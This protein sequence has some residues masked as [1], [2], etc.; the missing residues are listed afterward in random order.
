MAAALARFDE[1]S[2][3]LIAARALQRRIDRKYLLSQR[4]LEPVLAGLVADYRVARAGDV[5]TARYETVY[6]DTVHR[7]L[8]DDHRRGR[9]PRYKVRLRHHCDRR[10]TFLEVKRRGGCTTKMR[11]EL[12]FTGGRPDLQLSASELN[13]AAR[14]FVDAHCPIG[15]DRL[16]PCVWVTFTRLTLVGKT[17][18]ERATFDWNIA[19]GDQSRSEQLPALVVAEVKQARF[20]NAGPVAHALRRL[21]IRE[22]TLSKYCLA[23]VRLAPVR[24]NA[25]KPALRAV[26]RVIA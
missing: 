14:R 19:F 9:F 22:E 16:V 7:R 15:A 18:D 23:T 24:A 10:R 11:L 3:E 8:F 6:F 1:A 17:L 21:H 5:L 2:L 25:F 4:L 13:D 26:E 20:A 12:P